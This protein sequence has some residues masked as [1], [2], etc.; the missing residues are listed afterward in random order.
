[1]PG[2]EIYT[3][4]S[5]KKVLVPFFDGKVNEG[6]PSLVQDYVEQKLYLIELL[7]KHHQRHLLLKLTARA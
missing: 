3:Y 6:F 2:I 7:I 1:M 4:E 5:K